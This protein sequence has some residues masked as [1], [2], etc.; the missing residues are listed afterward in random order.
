MGTSWL[1]N[2]KHFDAGHQLSAMSSHQL[3]SIPDPISIITSPW[4]E[5]LQGGTPAR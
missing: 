2:S 3:C 4:S 1:K 5:E